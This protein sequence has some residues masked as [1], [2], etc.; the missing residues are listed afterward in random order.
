MDKII[1][2][3]VDVALA[4]LLDN[5]P[6]EPEIKRYFECLLR[7]K[8]SAILE[9]TEQINGAD[10]RA[11]YLIEDECTCSINGGVP[12]PHHKMSCSWYDVPGEF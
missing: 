10:A 5:C 12:G 2:Q 8:F 11:G 7:E 3:L 1:Q 6:N 4:E 9:A